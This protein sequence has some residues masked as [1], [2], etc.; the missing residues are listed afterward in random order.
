MWSLP[1][2]RRMSTA[3]LVNAFATSYTRIYFLVEGWGLSHGN[4]F[5]P[6]I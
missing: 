5:F 4:Y 3:E 2:L 6:Y 1:A